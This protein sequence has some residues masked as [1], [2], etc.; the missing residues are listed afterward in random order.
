MRP[1]TE[2]FYYEIQ[3]FGRDE[4]LS[5]PLSEC[6]HVDPYINLNMCPLE[7]IDAATK[8]ARPKGARNLRRQAILDAFA[9]EVPKRNKSKMAQDLGISR[10]TLYSDIRILLKEGRLIRKVGAPTAFIAPT[11]ERM[12]D[13]LDT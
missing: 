12:N 2:N 4:C 5:C 10:E 3:S 1:D 9:P 6:V 8:R 11:G 7:N 13:G